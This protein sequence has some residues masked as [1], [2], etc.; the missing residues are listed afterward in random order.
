VPF[1]YMPH[2][3]QHDGIHYALG[4]NGSGVVMMN[5]LGHGIAR[6]ILDGTSDRVNAFDTGTMPTH[7]LYTGTPWFLPIIGT[8]Y[9]ARDWLDR[10]R[11]APRPMQNR[12]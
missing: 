7:P 8:Y 3:G 12:S 2:I 5:W 11:D 4:C 6:K 9:Q 10:R 1:D